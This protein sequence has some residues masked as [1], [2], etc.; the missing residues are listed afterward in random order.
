[1]LFS[2]KFMT[3]RLKKMILNR[4]TLTILCCC[5]LCYL[6]QFVLSKRLEETMADFNRKEEEQKQIL[7][8]IQNS[9]K[10]KIPIDS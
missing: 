8:K 5:M 1:M 9:L 2:R 4:K 10:Q 7:I 6:W 3:Q